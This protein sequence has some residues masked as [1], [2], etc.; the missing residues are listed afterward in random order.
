MTGA[1][2]RQSAINRCSLC[3]S[4]S[5]AT[6]HNDMVYKCGWRQQA[7]HGT[8]LLPRVLVCALPTCQI[9]SVPGADVPAPLICRLQSAVIE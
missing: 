4:T 9:S 8:L 5:K 6:N 1:R 2:S 7:V 3:A